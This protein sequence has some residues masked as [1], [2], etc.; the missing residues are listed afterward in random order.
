[1]GNWH[2]EETTAVAQQL[3]SSHEGGLSTQ[4]AQTRLEEVGPNELVEKGLKSVWLI[5]WEQLTDVMVIVLI[6]AAVIS[7]F[8]GEVQDMIV[9]IAIVLLNAILGVTQEYRA[10]QAIAALKK[11]AVPTVRVR[12]DGKTSEIS[13][14]ELVPGDV[15]LLE[16]GN[17]VPADGRVFSSANLKVEEAALTGESEP[18]EKH[19]KIVTGEDVPLGDRRNAVYMGT[20]VVYGR[21][22]VMITETGMA[23][24]LGH[25]ADLLQ[26]VVGEQT[27]L[28]ER[29]HLVVLR[30]RRNG[31]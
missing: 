25:I 28:Q 9:I 16:A 2:Q 6:V 15:V 23:T 19:N 14:R 29:S 3:E 12:R 21:G 1:M 7:A 24:E 27:P 4:K 10:E 5:L 13:A 11:L 22:E 31:G 18:V 20:T 26:S 30:L 8:I 17:V